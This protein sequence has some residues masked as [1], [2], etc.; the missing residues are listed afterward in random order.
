VPQH[1][2]GTYLPCSSSRIEGNRERVQVNII[3]RLWDGAALHA[4]HDVYLSDE[5]D[6]NDPWRCPALSRVQFARAP[7]GG[8]QSRPRNGIAGRSMLT[9][10]IIVGRSDGT[11]KG[12]KESAER[13]SPLPVW[14]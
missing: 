4:D 11:R 1:G 13:S 3:R 6:P 8:T 7:E 14:N 2:Q 9:R 12:E 5:D 10:P